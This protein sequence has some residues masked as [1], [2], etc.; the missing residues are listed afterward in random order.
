VGED[1]LEEKAEG[2]LG[3]FIEGRK[4]KGTIIATDGE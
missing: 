4:E 3:G 2:R 1:M